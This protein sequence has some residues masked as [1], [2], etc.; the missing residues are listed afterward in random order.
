MATPVTEKN[1]AGRNRRRQSEFRKQQLIEATLDC[2]DKLGI[3][4]TTLARIAERAGL[5]QGNVVFHFQSKEALLD[6][7]LRFLD[8]EYLS[9]WQ[10][11]LAAA[12]PDPM[13]QLCALIRASF[14]PRICNRRKISVW[15]AFWGESRSRPKYMRVCGANDKALADKFLSLCEALADQPGVRLS[16]A[17][18]ALSIQ[19]MIDGLWQNFLLGPPGLKREQAVQTVFELVDAIYPELRGN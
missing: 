16:P 17:T 15:Y 3:S 1:F 6:Q 2:I 13:S 4:Q 19:G 11:A 12:Q 14:A 10:A 8:D 5:S 18:A 7:T 9:N